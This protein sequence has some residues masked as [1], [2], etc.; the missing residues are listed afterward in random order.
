MLTAHEARTV[1]AAET[2]L[3][4]RGEPLM[5]LAARAVSTAV[6]RLLRE[7]RSRVAGA[8]VHVLVGGGNNGADALYAAAEL[9]ARGAAVTAVLLGSRTHE[10]AAT[11]ARAAGVALVPADALPEGA[12]RAAAGDAV[13]DGITGIGA[14]AGLREPAASFVARLVDALAGADGGRRPLVVAVDVPSGV[15][16]DDGRLVGPVLAADLTVTMG[17][18][19]PGLLLPPAALLAGEVLVV[20]LGL[21]LAGADPAVVRLERGDVARLWPVPS[22]RDHKYSRGVLG[23]VAGS[24]GYPGAAVLATSAAAPLVGMVRYLG[25]DRAADAVLARHPEVVHGDGRVQAWL[26]GSGIGTDDDARLA[27]A[28][29]ALERGLADG[30]PVVVDAGGLDV[31]P[32]RVPATVVLTPHAGELARLLAARGHD[33]TREEIEERPVEHLRLA[34]AA[35]GATVLL[36]GAVTLVAGPGTPVHAQADGTSWLAT[37]GAGDVLA[38]VVGA[39]LAGASDRCRTDA[40]AVAPLV[41]AAALLHGRAARRASG[42]G[43]IVAGDVARAVGAVIAEILED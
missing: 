38:G 9:A 28:R 11:A 42:G 4:D 16:V 14:E 29:D 6:A 3:L 20:D 2:P 5:A 7:R 21:D 22:P 15:G 35:T 36:K 17:T 25:P 34:V 41:A 39:V 18:A 1:V 12:G 37:A 26:V 13:V 24:A 33:V 8:V 43:P 31:L 30:L 27:Q 10:A 23:V 32:E 19:K 40:A